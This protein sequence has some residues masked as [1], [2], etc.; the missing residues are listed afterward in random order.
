MTTLPQKPSRTFKVIAFVVEQKSQ[1]LQYPKPRLTQKEA[2]HENVHFIQ[3]LG[4]TCETSKSAE[5][6]QSLLFI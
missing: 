2:F 4:Y 5:E 3:F 6:K 1:I